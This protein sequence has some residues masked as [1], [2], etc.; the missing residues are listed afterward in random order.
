MLLKRDPKAGDSEAGFARGGVLSSYAGDS[1][2]PSSASSGDA[3]CSERD[4]DMNRLVLKY[5]DGT[6]SYAFKSDEPSCW[7]EIRQKPGNAYGDQLGGGPNNPQA[8]QAATA[9]NLYPF[10][11][12]EIEDELEFFLNNIDFIVEPHAAVSQY[13][14]HRTMLFVMIFLNIF[15]EL[16][17]MAYFCRNKEMILIQLNEMYRGESADTMRTLFEGAAL[18]AFILGMLQCLYGIC[19]L[20]TNR[21]TSIQIFNFSMSLIIVVRVFLSY[22]SILNLFLLVVKIMTWYYVKYVMACLL[23]CLVVLQ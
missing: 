5:P 9:D 23:N 3:S 17:L 4:L 19:A 11:L 13:F 14:Y 22:L 15:F 10:Q 18:L 6:F 20:M 21:L 16:L 7:M 8:D 2:P 12:L 1:K